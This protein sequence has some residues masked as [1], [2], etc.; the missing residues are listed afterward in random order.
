[1]KVWKIHKIIGE[2]NQ[3]K[4]QDSII[5]S[6]LKNR[7]LTTKNQIEKFLHPPHPQDL[8]PKDL[9]F[10]QTELTKGVKQIKQ[11]IKKKQS[12]IVYGD[13]DA[14]GICATAI[15]W[16]TLHHLGAQALPFI[17]ERLKHGYGIS[18]KGL[19]ELTKN[20]ASHP[21]PLIITV[22]NGI[23]AHT[24]V[25]YARQKGFDVI[26]SDHHVASNTLPKAN[27]IIHTTK[28]SGS[29]VA[30]V[31]SQAIAKSLHK[32]PPDNLELAAIGSLADMVPLLQANR[33]IVKHGLKKLSQTK[34]IGLLQLFK[35]ARIEPQKIST[36]EINFMITPRLNAMGR[37]GHALDSLR[38]LCTKS[39][40]RASKLAQILSSTNRDR[41]QLTEDQ[42]LH[43]LDLVRKSNREEKIIIV[44]HSDYHE[45]VIGLIAGRLMERYWR[46]TIVLSHGK[47]T[48]KASA[49]SI[50]GFN[51]IETLRQASDLLVDVGGHPMAAGF[52]VENKKIDQL[53]KKLQKIAHQKITDK[54]LKKTLDID[55]EI[56]LADINWQ[57]Y[58]NLAQF[59]PFGIANPQPVFTSR[60]VEVTEARAVGQERKHLKLSVREGKSVLPG[61]GFGL[62]KLAPKIS[63]G[64]QVDLAY[65]IDENNW[66]G[67]KELQLKIKDLSP[68]PVPARPSNNAF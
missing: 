64:S 32:S 4:R 21:K 38:L 1:M 61:I 46:P 6:L 2:N 19:D 67:R 50:P 55:C 39:Q 43:A 7:G 15:L 5:K 17:P 52:T 47:T 66:N 8:K 58:R 63:A 57:L 12:I 22:D 45:G 34:R 49:R 9:S 41:Q 35:D 27:A 30:W 40:A 33:S 29:G 25:K 16:E 28:L 54:L 68:V 10:N 31:L 56:K 24:A 48:S 37:L 20:Y 59:E 65:L 51:I 60:K 44:G 62:G 18:K 23:V 42:L 53:T 14:D 3:Q 11:A 36:Y 13:Y 26:I